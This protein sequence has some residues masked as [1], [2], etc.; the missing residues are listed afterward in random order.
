MSGYSFLIDRCDTERRGVTDEPYGG[1]PAYTSHLT[2]VACRLVTKQQQ[3]FNSITAQWL[4]TTQ[5]TLE[6]MHGTDIREGDRIT[7]LVLDRDRNEEAVSGTFQVD[8]GIMP[9]R[10]RVHRL[11]KATLKRVA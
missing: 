6:L 8:G 3:G 10:G 4:V 2:G 5:Y 7:N 1:K 11:L 9:S